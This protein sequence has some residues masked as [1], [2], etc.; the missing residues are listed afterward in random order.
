AFLSRRRAGEPPERVWPFSL[1]LF[2]RSLLHCSVHLAWAS[3]SLARKTCR[4]G[5]RAGTCDRGVEELV[6]GNADDEA[7]KRRRDARHSYSWRTDHVLSGA[8]SQ[9]GYQVRFANGNR[10]LACATILRRGGTARKHSH[11]R[12]GTPREPAQ[13]ETLP[14]A[15]APSPP[16]VSS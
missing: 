5:P 16:Y 10:Q 3:Q 6:A 13:G 11:R 9:G 7:S 2:E 14:A 8:H 15:G 12:G 4:T 1:V